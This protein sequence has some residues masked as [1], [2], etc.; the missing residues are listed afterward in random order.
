[1]KNKFLIFLGIFIFM[2][3][4]KNV[5]AKSIIPYYSKID[6]TIFSQAY[7]PT[8]NQYSFTLSYDYANNN[9]AGKPFTLL[10]NT[11]NYNPNY[12][13]QS[14]D[15]YPFIFVYFLSNNPN[16]SNGQ[17]SRLYGC[18]VSCVNTAYSIKNLGKAGWNNGQLYKYVL[19]LSTNKYVATANDVWEVDDALM[20]YQFTRDT[21]TYTITNIL[22]SDNEDVATD[23][24]VLIDA[25]I[26]SQNQNTQSIINNITN[27]VN[28]SIQNTNS[29]IANQNQIQQQT[30]QAVNETNQTMKDDNIDNTY[31]NSTL[32]NLNSQM[33]SNSVISDLLLLPVRMYQKILDGLGSN[34][35]VAYNLGSLYGTDLVLPCIQIQNYIGSA[36][37]TTIDLIFCGMFI[38]V[39]RKKFVDIFNNMT[40]L[41]DGGNEIE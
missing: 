39:I 11:S 38:L 25:L 10:V 28:T 40:N 22:L 30:T 1:M 20:Y 8:S 23:P 35:C 5:F 6:N 18:N 29:I 26:S 13:D 36:L 7:A 19:I 14:F 24:S 21:Y 37:W 31:Q 9:W 33:A 17:I 34:S 12:T 41:K 16:M 15:N 27:M 4:P 32:D 2:I 3:I